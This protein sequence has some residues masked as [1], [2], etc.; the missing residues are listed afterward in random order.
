MNRV[1]RRGRRGALPLSNTLLTQCPK[2]LIFSHSGD[3]GI[4]P[5]LSDSTNDLLIF[6]ILLPISLVVSSFVLLLPLRTYIFWWSGWILLGPLAGVAV[7][8]S[9]LV[10]DGS[11]DG[12]D[13]LIANDAGAWTLTAA[14]AG[15]GLGIVVATKWRGAVSWQPENS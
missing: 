7:A 1:A 14:L 13:V 6:V 12:S 10:L 9:I 11:E 3:R 8:W 15:I 5:S 4:N 2:N